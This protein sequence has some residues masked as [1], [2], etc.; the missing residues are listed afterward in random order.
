VAS[1]FFG[2]NPQCLF[3]GPTSNYTAAAASS[4]AAQSLI[5][6]STG[7]FDQPVIPFGFWP[8]SSTGGQG[9]WGALTGIISGQSSATTAIIT[10]GLVSSSNSIAGTSL[11]ATSAYTVTS[12][13]SAAWQMTFGINTRTIGYG[14]T[15]VSTTLQTTGNF[16][17]NLSAPPTA[18]TSNV[19]PA[20]VVTTIDASVN[21]WLYATVTFNTSSTSNSCTLQQALLFGAN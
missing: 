20:N 13:S 11:L 12:L 2:L 8:Q 1:T 10:I 6:G 9:L 7:N 18:G 3:A 15:T 21:Q 17:I 5:T 4:S 19:V 14:T 16:T